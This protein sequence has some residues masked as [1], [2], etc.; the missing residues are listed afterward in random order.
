MQNKKLIFFGSLLLGTSLIITGCTK[1]DSTNNTPKTTPTASTSASATPAKTVKVATTDQYTAP[2]EQYGQYASNGTIQL[3]AGDPTYL[4]PAF[5]TADLYIK[6][7]FNSAYLFSG[8]WGQDDYDLKWANNNGMYQLLSKEYSDKFQEKVN[9]AKADKNSDNIENLVFV[10]DKTLGML[11]TCQADAKQL[12]GNCTS[13]PM[14]IQ[15]AS[16]NYKSKDDVELKI[17]VNVNPIYQKPD[18]SEGNTVTQK[19]QYTFNFKL[20]YSAAPTSKETKTPIM[21]ITDMS[22]SLDIQGTEDFSVNEAM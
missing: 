16:Y 9:K 5:Y 21:V 15:D 20:K 19:R 2:Q 10:P 18:S 22:S 1:S 6:D 13:Y 7:S 11:E 17:V 12:E 8:Q 14:T 4:F 3:G